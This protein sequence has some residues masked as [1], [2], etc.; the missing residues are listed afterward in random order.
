M[1]YSPFVVIIGLFLFF[2]FLYLPF[3]STYGYDIR[4]V[5]G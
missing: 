4:A 2:T 3:N 5:Y 1:E